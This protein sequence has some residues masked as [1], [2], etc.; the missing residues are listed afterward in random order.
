MSQKLT[1]A[2]KLLLAAA[3]L[4][5][6]AGPVLL[7]ILHTPQSRA[8]T[9]AEAVTFE[10]ASI[11]PADPTSNRVS[12]SYTPDGGLNF[13]NVSL[14]Q[15]IANAYNIVCGK[16]CDERISGGPGWIDSARFDVLTKGPQLPAPGH[17]TREQIRQAAQALLAERF[18]LVI[19]RETKAMPEIGRAHV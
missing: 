15:L 19:R 9:K 14:K 17:A 4:A 10:V 5:A 16:A 2:R 6:V 12:M 18:K 1:I 7:G 13:M 3:G 8:Q 11:K